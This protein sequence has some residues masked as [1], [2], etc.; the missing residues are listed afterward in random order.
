MAVI[1]SIVVYDASRFGGDTLTGPKTGSEYTVILVSQN[2]FGP[3][4]PDVL[5]VLDN[6]AGKMYTG[7]SSLYFRQ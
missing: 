6:K 2:P 3:N 7:L 4:N 1:G 5:D